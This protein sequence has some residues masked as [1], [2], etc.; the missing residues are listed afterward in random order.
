MT[1][2]GPDFAIQS[3]MKTRIV[4]RRA[5]LKRQIE[6]CQRALNVPPRERSIREQRLAELLDT[7]RYLL[8]ELENL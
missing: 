3:G 6:R 4:P 2:V 5:R 7:Y 8:K 1:K